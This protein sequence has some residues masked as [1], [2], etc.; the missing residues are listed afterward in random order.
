M[1]MEQS[2]GGTLFSSPATRARS[3][4]HF[5][6][7]TR[8]VLSITTFWSLPYR[9]LMFLHMSY[10]GNESKYHVVFLGKVLLGLTN[11]NFVGFEDRCSISLSVPGF[12]SFLR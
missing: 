1:F 3:V 5:Y 8:L 6:L 12:F 4:V 11:M 7:L 9:V 2:W 10:S